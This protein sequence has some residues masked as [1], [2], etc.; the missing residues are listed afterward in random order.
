MAEFKPRIL[1]VDDDAAVL[2]MLKRLLSEMKV[3]PTITRSGREAVRLIDSQKF[4]GAILDYEVPEVDGLALTRCIRRSGSNA[5]IP[6]VMISDTKEG[7]SMDIIFGAGVNFHLQKPVGATQLRGL[8]NASRGAMLEERRR[9]QRVPI[10]MS[11]RL[12]W[13][14]NHAQGKSANLGP[15]GVLMAL[16]EPPK[17]GAEV[18][19]EFTLPTQAAPVEF[20]GRVARVA[21]D[22]PEGHSKGQAVAI[23]FTGEEQPHRWVLTEF[24]ENTLEALKKE[25]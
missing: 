16:T 4:E 18:K 22:P 10:V 2:D 24:V 13:G 3:E 12:Q 17:Q 1:V 7:P 21:A 11:I 25:S 19:V 15:S 9:Y 8:L 20:V 5:R 23:E 6:V 14:D